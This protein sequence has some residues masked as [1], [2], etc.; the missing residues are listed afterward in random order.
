MEEIRTAQKNGLL[1]EAFGTGTAA[2][3]SPIGEF[4]WQ[5]E[6]LSVNNGET[7]ELSAKLYDYPNRYSDR[8]NRRSFWLGCKRR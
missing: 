1:D 3:I 8:E 6:K 4:N 2:V 7:G 5:D